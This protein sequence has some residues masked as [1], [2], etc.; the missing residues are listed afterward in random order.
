MSAG[1]PQGRMRLC[2]IR[3]SWIDVE[4]SKEGG[5]GEAAQTSM[6]QFANGVG[7]VRYDENV[8]D[9]SESLRECQIVVPNCLRK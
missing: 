2:P 3:R 8:C 9:S 7:V 1:F 5:D 6:A 4:R